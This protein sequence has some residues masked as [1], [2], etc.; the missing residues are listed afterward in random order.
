MFLKK[1]KMKSIKINVVGEFYA[2]FFP[3]DVNE[4]FVGPVENI[5]RPADP[6]CYR[7]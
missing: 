1:M 6:R 3:F 4:N 7:S 5:A 2:M